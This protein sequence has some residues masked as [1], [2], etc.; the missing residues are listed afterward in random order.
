[1][2]K[3][4]SFSMTLIF[5][6]LLLSRLAFALSPIAPHDYRVC[7]EKIT[8]CADVSVNGGVTVFAIGESFAS[9]VLYKIETPWPGMG[10]VLSNNGD[11]VI[12]RSH[13]AFV[14]LDLN[15]NDVVFNIFKSGKVWMDVTAKD[16]N[17]TTPFK[18]M[19]EY[20][21]TWKVAF[22][23]S[24]PPIFS[25]DNDNRVLFKT[26]DGHFVDLDLLTKS[27]SVRNPRA[28]QPL[29]RC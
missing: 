9:K 22:L 6:C 11:Y 4:M 23:V 20:E 17:L 21:R 7:S 27:F 15:A 29:E 18:A 24:C 19:D 10:I 14:P 16:L 2:K 26:R 25:F 5:S 8:A 28:N 3:M 13:R 1:M 12:S